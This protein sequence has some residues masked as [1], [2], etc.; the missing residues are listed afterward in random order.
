MIGGD[1]LAVQY[2]GGNE[3]RQERPM[4]KTPNAETGAPD[5]LLVELVQI[6][7]RAAAE[8]DYAKMRKSKKAGKRRPEDLP[9]S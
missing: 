5:P 3:A 2:A 9:E 1:S 7:A 8:R 6:L 4:D